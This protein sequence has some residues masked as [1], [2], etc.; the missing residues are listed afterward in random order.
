DGF[1]EADS[2]GFQWEAFGDEDDAAGAAIAD[3][4]R[5]GLPDLVVGHHYNSTL[6]RGSE[7]PVRVY[8][9][10]GV[11]AEGLPIFDDVTT[12][13]GLP[14]LETKAP[15]VEIADFDN[16]GWPDL[17][18]TASADAGASPAVFRHLG[19]NGD[20]IPTFSS[21]EGLGAAQYWVT[22]P[23]ADVDRDGR[24]DIMLVE[25]EPTLPSLLMLND[26][27]SGNW[28]EVSVDPFSSRQPI[29]TVV[30]VWGAG[31][32]GDP[33]SLIG[34]REIVA[35]QG[36]GAGNLQVV[37]FGLG[38]AELVDIRVSYPDGELVE[39]LET[40]VNRHIQLPDG[41]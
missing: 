33:D 34:V 8:L 28:L 6:S 36:Y 18:T 2:T 23:T 17:L 14:G 35:S 39:L 24:L 31:G 16:D 7:V 10:R 32:L 15:H 27:A 26:T 19:V 41:C 21:P 30:G 4:N 13:T 3:L 25:W 22:G 37:H 1:R 5:D 38:D 9:N 12:A 11:D 29:G 40:D 20:G